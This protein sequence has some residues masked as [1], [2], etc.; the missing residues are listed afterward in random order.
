MIVPIQHQMDTDDNEQSRKEGIN[1]DLINYVSIKKLKKRKGA[2]G[3]LLF[4]SSYFC[5]LSEN[6]SLP[7]P[8][9]NCK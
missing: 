8:L 3:S 6:I 5:D 9:K 4:E 1:E 2:R 7:I